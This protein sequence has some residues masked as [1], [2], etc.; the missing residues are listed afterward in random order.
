MI[1]T[2]RGLLAHGEEIKVRLST[3]KGKIG[4]K[5]H[6]LSVIDKDPGTNSMECVLKIFKITQASVSGTVDF[7]DGNL[8]GMGNFTNNTSTNYSLGMDI[9]FDREVFNQDIFITNFD[10]S[11]NANALN[12]YLELEVMDMTDNAAAV[13]TLRDIRLNPQKHA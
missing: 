8:L 1:K 13:S 10:A 4:Y 3:K 6:H 12:Y 5:I 11:G 2:F 7:S 9:I